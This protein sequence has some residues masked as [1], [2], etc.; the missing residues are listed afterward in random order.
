MGPSPSALIPSGVSALTEDPPGLSEA[1]QPDGIATV[2]GGTRSPTRARAKTEPLSLNARVVRFQRDLKQTLVRLAKARLLEAEPRRQ[3][4]EQFSGRHRPPRPA[5]WPADL[6]SR[7]RGPMTTAGRCSTWVVAG[8]TYRIARSPRRMPLNTAPSSSSWLRKEIHVF[9]WREDRALVV[10]SHSGEGT[11]RL[12]IGRQ[13][14][15]VGQH[16]GG[17]QQD[18]GASA[19]ENLQSLNRD[20]RRSLSRAQRLLNAVNAQRCLAL[21]HGDHTRTP[22]T[23]C[24]RL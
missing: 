2:P 9:S 24:G 20:L 17:R 10:P 11:S 13:L 5:R 12:G 21:E 4:A 18:V 7:T 16:E 6:A 19:V 15:V 23:V 1:H 22:V 14:R 8:S 3:A